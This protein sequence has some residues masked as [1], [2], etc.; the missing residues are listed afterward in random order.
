[1]ALGGRLLVA[2]ALIYQRSVFSYSYGRSGPIIIEKDDGNPMV[3]NHPTTKPPTVSYP[4]SVGD[5]NTKS[6]QYPPKSPTASAN[7]KYVWKK[8][9]SSSSSSGKGS[10][11]SGKGGSGKGGSSI[12]SAKGASHSSSKGSSSKYYWKPMSSTSSGKGG[13][14]GGSSSGTAN[15]H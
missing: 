6:Q 15:S 8:P 11:S 2:F 9:V 14:K 4:T 5:A 7:T 3:A 10:D 12:S 1:M 13:G